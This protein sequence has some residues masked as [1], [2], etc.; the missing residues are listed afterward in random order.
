MGK[1]DEP[2]QAPD[3]DLSTR[4]EECFQALRNVL[5]VVTIDLD[6]DDD[7]QVIFETLNARGE[8]LLPADLLRNFIFLRAARNNEPVEELYD[9]YW[10]QFDSGFWRE[11]VRQGRLL[12]PRSDLFIQ[13][14][15]ASRRTYDIPIRYLYVEYKHWLERENPFDSVTQELNVLARQREH[16]RRIIQ[17]DKDDA[18]YPLA[19]FLDAFDIRTS[20]PLLLTLL[21]INI[22]AGEWASVSTALE[23]YLLRRSICALPTRN[24]NRVFLGLARTLR[25]EG[26]SVENLRNR[27]LSQSGAS[28]EWPSD[29][30]FSLAWQGNPV[31][32]Q[33]GSRKLVYILKRLNSTYINSKMEAISVRNELTI[34]HIMPQ[35]WVD[36]WPLSDG[37]MGMTLNELLA[38][39]DE[40]GDG[41][42]DLQSHVEK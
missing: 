41:I 35:E 42:R 36:K 3:Q 26:A 1:D 38:L 40:E 13:H 23:S 34:E 29:A 20:Y 30:E 9:K 18:L 10:K 6:K 22:S 37:S 16:F 8:P 27:L 25:K 15:L 24:Y 31:Y 33:L 17:P 39:S 19:T 12:R 2:P 28:V 32:D 14:F 4:L 5:Q 21:D 7:P 11:S